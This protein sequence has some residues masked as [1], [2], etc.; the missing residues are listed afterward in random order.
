MTLEMFPRHRQGVRIK[1][2]PEFVIL[3]EGTS[4]TQVFAPAAT[5]VR[6]MKAPVKGDLGKI[7]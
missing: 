1:T 5:S 6:S 2:D 4:K 7:L 3:L